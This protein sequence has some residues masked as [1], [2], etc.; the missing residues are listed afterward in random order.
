MTKCNTMLYNPFYQIKQ[1]KS[2]L[3]NAS[4]IIKIAAFITIK[5]TRVIEQTKLH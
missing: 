1:S 3:R 2:E 5:E 4:K